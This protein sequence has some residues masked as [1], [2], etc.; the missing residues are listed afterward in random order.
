MSAKLINP[1]NMTSSFSNREKIRRKPLS[2]RNSRSISWHRLYMTRL[3]VH[4]VPRFCLGGTTG[5]QPRSSAS[6]RGSL[7]MPGPSACATAT[8][9]C[10]ACAGA[11]APRARRGPGRVTAQMVW[12]FE[13]PR[14]PYESWWSIRRGTCRWLAGRCF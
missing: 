9:L 11:C 4:A 13:H 12:P 1:T 5:I 6:G 3:Y 8:E 7:R 10:P 2:L 14:H